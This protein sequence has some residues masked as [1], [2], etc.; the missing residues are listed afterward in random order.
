MEAV[1]QGS[2]P[3]HEA[4]IN[5]KGQIVTKHVF[6]QKQQKPLFLSTASPTKTTTKKTQNPTK[7]QK[8]NPKSTKKTHKE[9]KQQVLKANPAHLIPGKY[10]WTSN[11]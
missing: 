10:S 7:Q 8:K 4:G 11:N 6:F 2:L 1:Y 5:Q 9:F 3:L